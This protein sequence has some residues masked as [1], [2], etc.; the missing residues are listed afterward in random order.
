[1]TIKRDIGS[2]K[3]TLNFLHLTRNI[4]YQ[5]FKLIRKVAIDLPYNKL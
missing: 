4:D 3:I 2:K 5:E 1:M